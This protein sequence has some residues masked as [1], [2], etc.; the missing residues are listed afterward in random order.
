MSKEIPSQKFKKDFG[1]WGLEFGHSLDI[2]IW[3]LDIPSR[4]ANF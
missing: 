4:R 1:N 3:K 2:G